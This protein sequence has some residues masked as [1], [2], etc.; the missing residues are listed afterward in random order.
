MVAGIY[1]DRHGVLPVGGANR[2]TDTMLDPG[3]RTFGPPDLSK[4]RS[5]SRSRIRHPDMGTDTVS[6]MPIRNVQRPTFN[7]RLS[8]G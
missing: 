2:G 8:M 7:S 5:D 1:G 6:A 4:S 3:G